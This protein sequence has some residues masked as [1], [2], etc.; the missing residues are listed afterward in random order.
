MACTF[1]KKLHNLRMK[2]F[3]QRSCEMFTIE[4]LVALSLRNFFEFVRILWR[5]D[6]FLLVQCHLFLTR[7]AILLP[8]NFRFLLRSAWP[9]NKTSIV[10]NWQNFLP[11]SCICGQS[12]AGS[13][14]QSRLAVATAP[15]RLVCT[16]HTLLAAFVRLLKLH[17][18]V[19]PNQP[20]LLLLSGVSR[21]LSKQSSFGTSLILFSGR[22]HPRI[23]RERRNQHLRSGAE[24]ISEVEGAGQDGRAGAWARRR[25]CWW[26]RWWYLSS[27]TDVGNTAQDKCGWS[28]VLECSRGK[29][30]T[31]FIWLTLARPQRH[32]SVHRNK[33]ARGCS[34]GRPS[35]RRPV[36]HRAACV[37][38][39][40]AL[41][42]LCFHQGLWETEAMF[43]G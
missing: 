23:K 43:R 42:W 37:Y 35:V 39:P 4:L 15:L 32:T 29:R 24:A 20:P 9:G 25:R 13:A 14:E 22:N 12:G 34:P 31:A 40:P 8:I 2:F 30:Q 27:S 36:W 18:K 1:I 26:V 11:F 10:S 3:S 17:G 28:C 7:G 16:L 38:S 6:P 21:V 5:R 33:Q 19:K 41:K